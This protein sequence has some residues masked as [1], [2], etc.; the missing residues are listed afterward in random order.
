MINK[1]LKIIVVLLLV[2]NATFAGN[3]IGIYD[4]RYTLQADLS[5][6]QGLNL[7]WDDVHA[8]ATL[9]GVVNRDT[10]RLYVYFVMEGNNDI[11]GYWWNKYSRK[12]EWLYGRET[13]T[14]RTMEELFTAYASYIEGVVVYDGNVPSTSNVA[15]S[16]AGIENLVAIRY[17]DTPGSLYDRLVV[18]GPKLP[19]KRW[20]LNPD[21]TSMFTGKKGMEIPETSRLSTGSLK[22]DPYVWFIE[23][24]M[25]TGKCNTEFAAYYIDQF[26]RTD[27]TR[28]V[29]NHHQLTNHDFFVSK[30]AFF[31]DLSPW[32]DEPA[33]DDPTQEEG[34]DLQ[35]LKTF[36]QEA[37][38]QNKGEKFCYI[39]GFPSWIYKYTQHAGGKHEDVATEW[40][41]S[42]IISAYNAFKDADAIG[43]GALANSSFWQHFP[44]QE[45][46]PQKWVTHQELMDRGYLNRD[47]TINFQGRN[48][49]L[50]YV[51]DYDSSSWIAQTT[52]FLWDEPSRGE[53]P[54]MWSV[55]PVLA[56]RVPMVMHNYRVTATPNDYF[57]AA[58]NGAGYL[59]PGMLQEP[60]SVS[61]LKSGLSAWA[62]H[63]SKYYQ[64]WGLT[65]T[66]FVIDGEAPG[67]DSDG[68]D[69]YASFSPNGIVPQKMPLT[70][71]HNDMP[72]IR[73][74]YDIVDHDYRRATDVIVER[75]EK[76]PVPFHWFRAI[77]KSPSWYK[78]ICD[79]LK[80]RH[81]NIELL[82]AP[83]FFELYRIYL[84]QHPD[85]AAGK[86]TMN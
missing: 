76:R 32:G 61:G 37:Y 66:G 8:V 75:V 40:E 24:Y 70:L 11:D 71:L 57:A 59:M 9:Q 68:L 33:T 84:Q 19:V 43:L 51:G 82:D 14:Y 31:F 80:Q 62:K 44:L 12:G 52:P 2:A 7:A 20:L 3:K 16:V 38:K 42:R 85:A 54:L 64:K 74:D 23:K 30:K 86:I 10:P 56:E 4:L 46:Y 53:V 60:R 50:F 41:F 55:S 17:D 47:G 6:A 69:C 25:K 81:T 58:D 34:L 22:N 18:H 83:T 48:F 78:G 27:P 67:L 15:S 39:G 29:T 79:E 13:Q 77:L 36:L 73:A 35:I 72:V 5:T 45:K 63:C 26:W 1:Y 21:G 65:I 28:T 49:I